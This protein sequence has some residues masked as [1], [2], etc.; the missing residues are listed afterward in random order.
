MRTMPPLDPTACL[1]LLVVM[2]GG[3]RL[4]AVLARRVGQPAVLGELLAGVVL[5]TSVLGLVDPKQE[6]LHLLADLGVILLL[7]EIGLETD[8]GRLLRVGGASAAVAVVGVVLPFALGYGACLLLGL[9]ARA[10]VVAG[11]ALTA[12]SVGITA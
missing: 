12:T 9:S 8:L 6:T 10:A 7:F 1:G 11:A 3:A 2:L 5:G 4:G